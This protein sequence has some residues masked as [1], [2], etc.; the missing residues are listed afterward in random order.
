MQPYSPAQTKGAGHVPMW[1]RPFAQPMH[2]VAFSFIRLESI[3]LFSLRTHLFYL[4]SAWV[5]FPIRVK[6]REQLV[7]LLNPRDMGKLHLKHNI[8]KGP[9]KI[10]KKQSGICNNHIGDG[11]I[12]V[13]DKGRSRRTIVSCNRWSQQ[14]YPHWA[15][16]RR[17]KPPYLI[18]EI[19]SHHY[20]SCHRR[21]SRRPL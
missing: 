9:K 8:C 11:Q 21:W 14:A 1:F 18:G 5:T 16:R 7:L 6:R 20:Q 15:S 2:T 3:A 19:I 17:C 10:Q 13:H 12:L 4:Q